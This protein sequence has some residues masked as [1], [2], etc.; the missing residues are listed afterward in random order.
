MPYWWNK[1]YGKDKIC[2]ITHI[3]LRSGYNKKGLTHVIFLNC[4]HGF[5]RSA[6]KNWVETFAY[7][8]TYP[9]CPLCREQFDPILVLK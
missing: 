1:K 6:L 8:T 3:R 9:T 4:K 2:G 7:K 5:Y